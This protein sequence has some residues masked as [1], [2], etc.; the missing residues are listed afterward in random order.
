MKRRIVDEILGAAMRDDANARVLNSDGSYERTQGSFNS[1]AV[2]EELAGGAP[3]G[4]AL[5]PAPPEPSRT[6]T[7]TSLASGNCSA[8]SK[9]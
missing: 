2:L 3:R 5:P 1:H 6:H 9:R 4:F 8:D 7:W